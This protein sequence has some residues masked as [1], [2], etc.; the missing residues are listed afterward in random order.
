[1]CEVEDSLSCW[2]LVELPVLAGAFAVDGHTEQAEEERK[3]LAD[4]L[5]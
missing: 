5:A 1:M 3:P 2:K 4:G